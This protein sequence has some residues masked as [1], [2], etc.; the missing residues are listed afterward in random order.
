MPM[1]I[2]NI[3]SSLLHQIGRAWWVKITTES[4]HCCYYF[5]PFAS[6]IAADIAQTGYIEDLESELAQGIQ[7]S[8]ECC[9]PAELTIDYESVD[10]GIERQFNPLPT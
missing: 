1:N 4:P 5:G 8:I 10:R 3:W 7:A 9:R 6:K 2:Q